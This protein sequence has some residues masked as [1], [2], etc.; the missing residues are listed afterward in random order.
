MIVGF[1]YWNV[2]SHYPRQVAHLMAIHEA[3][4]RI[5]AFTETATEV[6]SDPVVAGF[7]AATQNGTP[8]P[9]IPEMGSVWEHWNAA[10]AAII[11][12]S[13]EPEAAWTKMVA[14]IEAAIGG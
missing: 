13:A 11:S 3:D 6:A 14:D 4:P 8:M 7:L 2:L 10:Q 12:G 1:D 5:P 9:S